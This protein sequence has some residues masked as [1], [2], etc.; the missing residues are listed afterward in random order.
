MPTR[1]L[2]L[3]DN[4][5]NLDVLRATLEPNG[6]E[7]LTTTNLPEA[8]QMVETAPPDLI[9]SDLYMPDAS[10]FEF[11]MKIK[12]NSQLKHIPFIVITS[13]SWNRADRPSGLALGADKF[14]QRPIEPGKL[15]REIAELVG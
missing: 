7:V 6:Y 9:L 13:Q 8:L 2:V 15:L 3:D 14:I 5:V 4:P 10:G 12:H 11:L 1:I